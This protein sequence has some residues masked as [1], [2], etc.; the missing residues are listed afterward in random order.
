MMPMAS[1]KASIDIIR[2]ANCFFAGASALA[3]LYIESA[4]LATTLSSEGIFAFVAVALLCAAGNIFNDYF[5][6]ESDCINKPN[7]P[8]PSGRMQKK[9]S[10][11]SRDISCAHRRP[12]SIFPERKHLNTCGGKYL[13]SLRI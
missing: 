1:L 8:I 6:L 10:S 7:R 3:A 9:R 4:S 13:N 11:G 2:P 12:C 5:D